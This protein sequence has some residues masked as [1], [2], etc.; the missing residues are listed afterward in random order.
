ML[1]HIRVAMSR[2]FALWIILIAFMSSSSTSHHVSL[3]KPIRS[4]TMISSAKPVSVKKAVTPKPIVRPSNALLCLAQAIFF[5]AA[6][7]PVE[8][9]QAVAATV[10]NRM[11]APSYPSS[12]CGVVYQPYQYSWTLVRTN[13]HRSPPQKYFQLAKAFLS[14]RNAL[15]EEYPVTHFHRIDIAPAWSHTLEPIVTIGQ[16]R[17]YKASVY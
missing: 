10:F 15:V 5:E 1:H 3:P 16:H 7:E 6:F 11:S 2:V 13:W 14:E 12:L 8:G 4:A 17:F 9:M